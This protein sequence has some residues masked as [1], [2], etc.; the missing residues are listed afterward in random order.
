MGLH[1]MWEC[2]CFPRR[3]AYV[4]SFLSIFL[5]T[6]WCSV[7][8]VKR[9]SSKKVRSGHLRSLVHGLSRELTLPTNGL[10]SFNL[11]TMLVA[12]IRA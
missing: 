7:F 4:L 11:C 3:V 5:S 2:R 6:K 10:G 1:R 9:A 8:V 12:S